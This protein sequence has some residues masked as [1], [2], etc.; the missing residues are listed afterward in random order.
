M[1][2]LLIEVLFD[3]QVGGIFE[4]FMDETDLARIAISGHFDLIYPAA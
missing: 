3:G 4:P 1:W 2:N